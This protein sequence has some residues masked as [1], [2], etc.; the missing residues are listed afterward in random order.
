MQILAHTH[1]HTNAYT[2]TYTHTHTRTHTH[3]GGAG[4]E[5]ERTV[6]ARAMLR[7]ADTNED[8]KIRCGLRWR[9]VG[10]IGVIDV[11][12]ML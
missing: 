2:H 8:G 10:V 5:A 3:T 11:R 9:V 4:G 7:E 1:A 12:F 6:E